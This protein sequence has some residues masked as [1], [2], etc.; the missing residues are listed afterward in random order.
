MGPVAQAAGIARAFAGQVGLRIRFGLAGFVAA[1]LT[2]EID[3]WITPCGRRGIAVL[4]DKAF[5]RSPG[6]DQ[7][8][9]DAEMLV[10]GQ[11]APLGQA[12]YSNEKGARDLL[13]EQA[14][15]ILREGGVVPD[16]SIGGQANK[17]A[18]QH[19]V[20]QWLDPQPFG[21]DRVE[22]LQQ[23]GAQQMFRRNRSPVDAG[24]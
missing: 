17:P 9:I 14:V 22:H 19:V 20:V 3:I 10:A 13:G 18:K 12:A 7:R 6:I 2:T 21:A 5:V 23:G 24:I 1:R 15:A 8:A 16:A 4:A 11:F